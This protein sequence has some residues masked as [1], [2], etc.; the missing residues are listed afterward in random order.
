[1]DHY[2]DAE[3]FINMCQE[4]AIQQLRERRYA[5]DHKNKFSMCCGSSVHYL[6]IKFYTNGHLERFSCS[7]CGQENCR[8]LEVIK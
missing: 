8:I 5:I 6:G 4:A 2:E 1:M 3:H 7:N